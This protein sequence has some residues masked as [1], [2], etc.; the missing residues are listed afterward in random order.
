MNDEVKSE[1]K[2]GN[3]AR[4]QRRWYK[5]PLAAMI[6]ALGVGAGGIATADAFGDG[7]RGWRAQQARHME[8]PAEM[9]KRVERGIKHLAIEIDATSEQEAELIGL[10]KG[11]V[12]D[13]HEFRKL[14]RGDVKDLAELLTAP[15]VDRAAIEAF[16][17]ER[18]EKLDQLSE[19][20]VDVVAQAGTCRLRS[21]SLKT[22]LASLKWSAT[23]SA[24]RVIK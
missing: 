12:K 11:A 22:I 4:G 5:T 2:T 9:E 1:A 3:N 10:A 8:D 21:F 13:L 24:R 15:T 17:A 16:R 7:K 19:R 18:I 6:I 23:I 20:L 14:M